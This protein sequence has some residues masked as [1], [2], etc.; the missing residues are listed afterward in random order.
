MGF[1]NVDY[2]VWDMDGTLVDSSQVVPDAFDR[3][4]AAL[5]GPATTA[6][7]VVTA[8]W[9]GTPEVILSFLVGRELAPAEY[10][11]YYQHLQGAAVAAYPGVLTTLAALRAK[12]L[13]VAVFTG[14]STRSARILLTAAGINADVIIGGDE[15]ARPKPAADGMLLAAQRLDTRPE[16]LALIGDSPLDLQA[17]TAAGS[18][19]ASAAWGHLYDPMQPADV[20]L[21][22]P[23]QTLALLKS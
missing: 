21:S 18:V 19:S 23:E 1:M 14:A 6:D 10:D 17:A 12:G 5:Q 13:P 9:R 11:L 20:T 3:A 15:I 8:Y 16:R 7:E 4:V 2:V 22:T